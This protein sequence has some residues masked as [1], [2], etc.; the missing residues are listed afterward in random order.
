M[1]KGS[2][3]LFRTQHSQ[4]HPQYWPW[5]ITWYCN[6]SPAPNTSS[7]PK[8][9]LFP[10]R[11]SQTTD[12]IFTPGNCFA[13]YKATMIQKYQWIWI[14]AKQNT[15]PKAPPTHAGAWEQYQ[16]WSRWFLVKDF[17][18]QLSSKKASDEISTYRRGIEQR[19]ST[20]QQ[21]PGHWL[22]R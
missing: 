7:S 9:N 5:G 14:I 20:K 17:G 10:T 13:A 18:Q 11:V 6:L 8:I 21:E 16:K 15:S 22:A 3:L 12:F 1:G 2:V 4:L 19:S